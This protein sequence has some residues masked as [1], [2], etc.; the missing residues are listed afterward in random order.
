MNRARPLFPLAFC[1]ECGQD[2]LV[3]NLDKG[4]EKFSP[5][6]LNDTRGEQADATG[7]LFLTDGDWPRPTDPALL[8]LRSRRLGHR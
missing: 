3:V 4:G 7:L 6:P 1:R 5:R 8:D 2:F